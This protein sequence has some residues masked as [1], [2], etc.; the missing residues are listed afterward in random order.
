RTPSTWSRRSG[1]G[2]PTAVRRSPT[3]PRPRG[4]TRRART[5][6]PPAHGRTGR[7]TRRSS[8]SEQLG[9]E[10]SDLIGFGEESVV[11]RPAGDRAELG[12]GGQAV[13]EQ[14]HLGRG[15]EAV[16]AD[17]GHEEPSARA[18]ERS[19]QIRAAASADVV[20]HEG[21]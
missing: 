10:R 19:A 11:A 17:S 16:A 6:A 3:G 8:G 20:V 13:G 5:T 15:V 18:G 21:L 9:D 1:T 4:R 12:T 2:R 14:L 7:R